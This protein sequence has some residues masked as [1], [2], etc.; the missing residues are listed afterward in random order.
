M[1]IGFW[2]ANRLKSRLAT[3]IH[4]TQAT[5]HQADFTQVNDKR[6]AVTCRDTDKRR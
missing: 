3:R 2:L 4:C 5:V 1:V 6:A